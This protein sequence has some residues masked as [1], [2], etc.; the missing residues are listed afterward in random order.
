VLATHTRLVV[1]VFEVVSFFIFLAV[2][3]FEFRVLNLQHR[4]STALVIL[5]TGSPKLFV[6]A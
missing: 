5:E 3:R 1:M 4:C 6:W 2:V